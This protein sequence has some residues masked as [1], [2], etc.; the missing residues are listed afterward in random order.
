MSKDTNA[1]PPRDNQEAFDRVCAHL[2][3]ADQ[4][5]TN[6]DGNACR[7]AGAN[8]RA[9]AVGCLLPREIGA[10][11][12]RLILTGWTQ[13]TAN[14]HKVW[15][16]ARAHLVHVD[17]AFLGRLQVAHD[18]PENWTDGKRGLREELRVIAEAYKLTVPACVGGEP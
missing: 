16:E 2:M 6:T 5:S 17:D 4:R 12:D 3:T 10:R 11:L 18:A 14:P 1:A 8:D 7:Y 15:C 13:A 9:C